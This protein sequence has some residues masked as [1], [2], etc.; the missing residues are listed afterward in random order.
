LSQIPSRIALLLYR[1]A[2][3]RVNLEKHSLVQSSQSQNQGSWNL[4]LDDY[5]DGLTVKKK[6]VYA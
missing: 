4:A 3:G 2:T 6:G 5:L 1:E